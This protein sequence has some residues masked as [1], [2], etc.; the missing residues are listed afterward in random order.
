M[1][2]ATSHSGKEASRMFTL[3]GRKIN[4]ANLSTPSVSSDS[5]EQTLTATSLGSAAE[6][7][8][9]KIAENR[10]PSNSGAAPTMR[11]YA[12][13]TKGSKDTKGAGLGLSER[14]IN[15]QR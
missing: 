8:V 5:G 14:N 4:L 12:Q 7:R 3:H 13:A 11:T 6:S 2:A 9:E 15:V 10:K 1:E